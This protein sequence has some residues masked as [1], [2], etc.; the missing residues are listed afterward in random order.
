MSLAIVLDAGPLGL[1]TQRR[2]LPEREACRQWIDARLHSGCRVLIAEIADYGVRRE[3]LRMRKSTSL[4]RLD[5]LCETLEY[6]PITTEA[7]RRAAQ[8]WA[9]ARRSGRPT[10]D[11]HAL[12]SDVILAGQAST[13]GI[14]N[15]VVATTNVA[16]LSRFVPA[17][18]WNEIG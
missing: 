12:D 9:E 7:M 3:L 15:V 2:A 4:A 5:V 13:M 16:H 18:P 6:L 14:T 10:A 17:K 8:F 11:R 1:V